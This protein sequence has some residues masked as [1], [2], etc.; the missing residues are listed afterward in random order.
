M[1]NI[2]MEPNQKQNCPEVNTVFAFP[3]GKRTIENWWYLIKRPLSY[4]CSLSFFWKRMYLIH[5]GMWE[6][7]KRPPVFMCF[8][9]PD[10]EED[11]K[12]FSDK[13]ICLKSS[14]IYKICFSAWPTNSFVSTC[15]A[16]K[17]TGFKEYQHF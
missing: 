6:S 13:N 3:S 10:E 11:Q 4:F 7:K 1:S 15:H 16:D 17:W 9:M 12:P 8:A 2:E 14:L 5:L